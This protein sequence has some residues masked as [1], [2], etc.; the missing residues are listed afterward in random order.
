M[1]SSADTSLQP[2]D[3]EER[4][5]VFWSLYLLDRIVSCGRARPPAILEASCQ[6][7]LPCNEKAWKEN[8]SQITDTLDRFSNKALIAESRMGPFA[9]VILMAYILSRGAQYMLQEYN[10]RSQYPPWDPNSDFASISSDLLY[11]ESHFEVGRSIKEVI[12]EELNKEPAADHGTICEIVFF[13]ALFYLCHCLL[14]HPFLMRHRLR[15][16]NTRAPSTFLMRAF[17][18]GRMCAKHLSQLMGDTQSL[19]CFL[20]ASFYG[21]CAVVAGSIQALYLHSTQEA[22]RVEAMQCVQLNLSILEE[23]GKFWENVSSM[24]SDAAKAS[25]NDIVLSIHS[26]LSW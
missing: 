14:N 3:K 15:S 12:T 6:L 18:F 21:Y 4:R 20:N 10:I 8:T 22:L 26:N 11:I 9:M 24:V 2:A 7:Q 16:S 17:D 5:R 1:D 19:G 25:S 23:V 13:R